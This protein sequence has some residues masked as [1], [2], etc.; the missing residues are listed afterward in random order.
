VLGLGVAN[1]S[2]A[3]SGG[4]ASILAGTAVLWVAAFGQALLYRMIPGIGDD[5]AYG[6]QLRSG[7]TPAHLRPSVT[8]TAGAMAAGVATHADRAGNSLHDV[9]TMTVRMQP[10]ANGGGDAQTRIRPEPA[11]PPPPRR[12]PAGGG[13]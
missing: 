6:R 8:T 5:L 2:T 12:P 4:I 10:G 9:A 11:A 7:V 3:P 1:T 13:A